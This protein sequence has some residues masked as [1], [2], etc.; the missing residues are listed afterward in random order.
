MLLSSK[1]EFINLQ[2]VRFKAVGMK[3]KDYFNPKV[4]AILYLL[5]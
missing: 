2:Q 5:S 3:K 1:N 4:N